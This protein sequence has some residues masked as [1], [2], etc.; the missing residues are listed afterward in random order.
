M[1]VGVSSD[2]RPAL[3]WIYDPSQVDENA[4]CEANLFQNEQVGLAMK[5]FRTFRLNLVSVRDEHVKAEHSTPSFLFFD[6]AGKQLGRLEGKK[7]DSLSAFTTHMEGAWNKSFETA[8][9]AYTRSMTKIL[10]RLDRV[11]A[12]KTILTQQKARLEEKPNARKAHEVEQG[13]KALA[14]ELAKVEEDEKEVLGSIV[15]R[16]EYRPAESKEKVADNR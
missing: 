5:K 4:S 3:V 12:Q 6:P 14:D 10:D 11:E 15:L 2:S 9:R 1:S 7:V 16:T 8:L 13:E